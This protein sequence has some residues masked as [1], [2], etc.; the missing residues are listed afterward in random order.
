MNRYTELNAKYDSE[1]DILYVGLP[2][3]ADA[4]GYDEKD[5]VVMRDA[6]SKELR[7][8]IFEG[9]VENYPRGVYKGYPIDLTDLYKRCCI[10]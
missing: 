10:L 2:D 3:F 9:F 4:I 1:Y 5:V 6:Q 8:Y 7:G